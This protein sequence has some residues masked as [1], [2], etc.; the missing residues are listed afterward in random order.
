M[1]WKILNLSYTLVLSIPKYS[2]QIQ[3]DVWLQ[4]NLDYQIIKSTWIN[5]FLLKQY[6]FNF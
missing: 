2:C 4:N 1:P 3:V 6:Y 5:Y